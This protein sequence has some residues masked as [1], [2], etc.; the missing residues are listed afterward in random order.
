M[1]LIDQLLQFSE[2][3]RGLLG[4]TAFAR[5]P[6][7]LFLRSD[8]PGFCIHRTLYQFNHRTAAVMSA[9]EAVIDTPD[10][11]FLVGN[12]IVHFDYHV[13]NVLVDPTR[14]GRISAIVDWGGAQP[15]L[16]EFDLALL[17]FDL[18]WRAPGA[19]QQRVERHLIETADAALFAKVWAHAALRLVDFTIRH[20]PND[21]DD[22]TDVGARHLDI[23]GGTPL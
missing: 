17:V 11:D 15:G 20:Y 13:G 21:V 9:I 19:I 10:D 18:S 2:L 16:V 1:E 6:M 23:S 3:R 5:I 14:G 7:P 8:G 12:D 22:W 4:G